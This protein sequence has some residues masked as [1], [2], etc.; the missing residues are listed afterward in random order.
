LASAGIRSRRC[1]CIGNGAAFRR[2]QI[3][4]T[5]QATLPPALY[6]RF[7]A[8]RNKYA[9]R[10]REMEDLRPMLAALRLFEKKELT[11]RV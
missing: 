8:L 1:V 3:T 11:P 6:A 10:D 5:L 2:T 9:P 7:S 4:Q